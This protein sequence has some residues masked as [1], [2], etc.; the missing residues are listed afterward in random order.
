MLHKYFDFILEVF[1]NKL[2]KCSKVTKSPGDEYIAFD[3]VPVVS[4][5]RSYG[6]PSSLNNSHSMRV[7]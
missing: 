7:Q 6:I 4:F 5:L 3:R 1:V 2:F